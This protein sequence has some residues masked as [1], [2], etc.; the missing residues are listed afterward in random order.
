[1]A[2]DTTM[3]STIGTYTLTGSALNLTF[4][5]IDCSDDSGGGTETD[6]NALTKQ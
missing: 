1:M 4:T 5:N 2:N 6:V 3:T